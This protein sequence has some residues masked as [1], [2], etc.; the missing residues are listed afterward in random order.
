LFNA[1]GV[2]QGNIAGYYEAAEDWSDD[3]KVR[4]IIA[5]GEGGCSFDL[6]TDRP[7][8]I[9][10]DVYACDS[11]RDLAEQFIDEGLFGEIPAAIADYLDYDAIA[12]DLSADYSETTIDGTRYIYRLG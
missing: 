10:L 6:G 2:H 9:D 12:R 7:E 8:R 5:A 11:L 3:E 1:L 4:V